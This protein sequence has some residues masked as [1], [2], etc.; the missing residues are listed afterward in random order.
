MTSSGQVRNE[1]TEAAA[2]LFGRHGHEKT[3]I[4]DVA[5]ADRIGTAIVHPPQGSARPR[6]G[7]RATLATCIAI[8]AALALAATPVH[9]EDAGA[10]APLLP[11]EAA[12]DTAERHN[13]LVAATAREVG[14]AEE[15]AAALRTRRLPAFRLDG[16]GGR[17]LNSPDLKIPAGSLGTVPGVG[18]F[19]PTAATRSVPADWFGVGVASVGQPITQQ[20]RIGLG[21]D[22]LRL[23][24]D[25]ASEDLRRERQRLAADVRTTYY[26]IS[27]N[28]AGVVSLRALIR[29]LEEVDSLSTRYRA[30][31]VVLRSE[32]LE[33]KARLARERQRLAA[34][35]SGLATHREHLN[36]LMGRE[37]G[38]PFR[39]STPSELAS[40]ASGLSLE[41]ARERARA[42]RPEIRQASLRTTQAETAR[43]L[44]RADWIPDLTLTASYARVA[45]SGVLPDETATVGLVFSWEPFEWGRRSHEARE[46]TLAIEQARESGE[47]A[48][49]QIQVEVGQRWRSLKDAALQLE[50]TRASQEAAQA[51]L[52]DTRNRFRENAK[53]LQDVLEAEFRFSNARRDFTDA[54]AGYWSATAE[55]ERTIGHEH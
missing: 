23:D 4:D 13:H 1:I 34:T 40:S 19:P 46:R 45:N 37:V 3:S 53:L 55:L 20:Y 11:L 31:D 28:E 7:R 41:A 51:Y 5:A 18:A 27:A 14:K 21:L 36:Q 6:R 39:V 17:L 30:E 8:R 50:A 33:V 24:R 43:R 2:R 26:Q 15:R 48:A 12:V 35:E 10:P 29:A 25:V 9:A 52:D 49:Q 44:A 47:E 42:A 32:A 16:Y 22:L 38:T 54:L